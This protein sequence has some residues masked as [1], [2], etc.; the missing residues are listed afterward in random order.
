MEMVTI[1]KEEYEHLKGLEEIDLGLISQ[2]ANSLKD[3]KEGN[4]K[5]L[6]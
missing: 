6:A 4:Y 3:L 5:R 2:F 1:S